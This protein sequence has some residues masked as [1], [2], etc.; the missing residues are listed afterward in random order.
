LVRFCPINFN[1][2]GLAVYEFHHNDSVRH[3]AFMKHG[4]SMADTLG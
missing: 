1:Q 3:A 2:E 4:D